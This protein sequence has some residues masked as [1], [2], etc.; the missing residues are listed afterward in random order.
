[1]TIE[2]KPISGLLGTQLELRQPKSDDREAIRH[3]QLC[4]VRRDNGEIVA[5]VARGDLFDADGNRFTSDV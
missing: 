2:R 1:M 4:L 5:K 3:D